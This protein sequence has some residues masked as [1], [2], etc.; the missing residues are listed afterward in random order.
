MCGGS[1]KRCQGAL[2][3]Y[4]GQAILSECVL[5]SAPKRKA[6][7]AFRLGLRMGQVSSKGDDKTIGMIVPNHAGMC[8]THFAAREYCSARY[9]INV[10]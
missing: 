4:I 6:E 2:K 3:V 7:P 1:G 9:R 5:P 8:C 10:L